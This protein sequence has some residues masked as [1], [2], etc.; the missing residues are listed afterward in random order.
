MVEL[1]CCWREGTAHM[2]ASDDVTLGDLFGRRLAATAAAA[3][4]GT[5]ANGMWSSD[6][7][8]R[9]QA[10]YFFRPSAYL[11]TYVSENVVTRRCHTACRACIHGAV[12]RLHYVWV[13]VGSEFVCERPRA[14][15]RF[16]ERST[17][18]SNRFHIYG[19][20]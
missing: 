5:H 14:R 20:S 7:A 6:S 10:L 2:A 12:P 1:F 19:V 11:H 4:P 15:A 9:R 17:N 16:R 8:K 18:Q 3:L 13:F